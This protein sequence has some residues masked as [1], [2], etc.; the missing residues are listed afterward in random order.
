MRMSR[1]NKQNSTSNGRDP[2]N[3]TENKKPAVIK[4]HKMFQKKG[5]Q[6]KEVD[7]MKIYEDLY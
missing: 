6:S 2:V 1:Y 3:M 5:N 4:R 7:R